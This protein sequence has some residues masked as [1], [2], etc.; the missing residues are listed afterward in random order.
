MKG[1]LKGG[2]ITKRIFPVVKSL[3]APISFLEQITASD[4]KA[5]GNSFSQAGYSTQLKIM[6]NMVMGRL[7]GITPFHKMSDGTM[8]P[9]SK[10]TINPSGVLNKWTNAGLIGLGYQLIG[11]Q[12]N[13]TLGK[14]YVPE[15]SKIGSISKSVFVGGALGGIFSPSEAKPASQ[16]SFPSTNTTVISTTTNGTFN[17]IDTTESSY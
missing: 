2:S 15:T 14:N 9:T 6:S 10:Q 16:I 8:L 17:T 5:L 11:S 3:S 1:L 4:R 13:K 12:I 7:A